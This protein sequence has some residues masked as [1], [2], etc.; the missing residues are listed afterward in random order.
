MWFISAGIW[1][2]K[3][4]M[5]FAEEMVWPLTQEDQ[6]SELCPEA[7]KSCTNCFICLQTISHFPH[8]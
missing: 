2:S 1:M 4:L 7:M 5:L 8:I 6:E 3:V